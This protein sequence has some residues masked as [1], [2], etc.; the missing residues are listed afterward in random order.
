[1]IQN[2]LLGL[3]LSYRTQQ[4]LSFIFINIIFKIRFKFF[5]YIFRFRDKKYINKRYCEFIEKFQ[6]TSIENYIFRLGSTNIF[7]LISVLW[8]AGCANNADRNLLQEKPEEIRRINF[9]LESEFLEERQ[10]LTY[11]KGT[12]YTGEIFVNYKN[13]SLI[14]TI[15]ITTNSNGWLFGSTNLSTGTN[16]SQFNFGNGYFGTS[17][18]ASANADDNGIGAFEYAPPTGYLALCTKNINE[19]EYS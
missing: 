3:R 12:P 6:S 11:F 18:V 19:Q 2:S 14:G 9:N 13:G 4:F 16:F 7:A 10:N 5:V 17:P 8:L 1:M 15:N